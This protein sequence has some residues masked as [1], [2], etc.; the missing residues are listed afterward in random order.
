MLCSM[1]AK[2]IRSKQDRNTRRGQYS[3]RVTTY[4]SLE[5]QSAADLR[6]KPSRVRSDG[7]EL[8]LTLYDRL[9]LTFGCFA[10][11]ALRQ[12]KSQVWWSLSNL[13]LCY[14]RR[15]FYLTF[16]IL[17]KVNNQWHS[18]PQPH[19]SNNTYYNLVGLRLPV[20]TAS[21]NWF[22][23]WWPCDLGLWP[24]SS[25]IQRQLVGPSSSSEPSWWL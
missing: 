15:Y 10:P 14:I 21:Q 11:K 13:L 20:V 6:I 8:M 18:L 24:F 23:T 16:K 17:L 2:L 9:T 25:K 5:M 4:S 12:M 22:C 3:T 7:R 1:K 19:S